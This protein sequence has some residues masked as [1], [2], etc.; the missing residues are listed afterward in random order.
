MR[1]DV[2]SYWNNIVSYYYDNDIQGR[3]GRNST[4]TTIWEWLEED[5]GAKHSHI[6]YL[7]F[8]NEIDATIFKLRFGL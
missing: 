6:S 8:N 2:A 3:D 7:I 4:N 1:I 5:F